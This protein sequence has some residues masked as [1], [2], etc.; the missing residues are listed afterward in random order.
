MKLV[1]LR[2]AKTIDALQ[3]LYPREDTPIVTSGNLFNTA[4]GLKPEKVYTSPLIRARQ[5]AE[6]LFQEYEILD[7]IYEYVAPKVLYAQ[8]LDVVR[9]FWKEHI[10][11]IRQNPDWK[12]DSSESFNEIKERACRF[13]TYMRSERYHSVT[14]VGH[15]TFFRHT[16][17]VKRYG[18]NYRFSHFENQLRK[19]KWDNLEIKELKL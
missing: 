6:M 13:L 17:G 9:N 8:P 5:T 4:S 7:F 2:H 10:Q 3:G 12:Y 1:L 16:I 18:K 11:Q 14:V 19:E 15:M